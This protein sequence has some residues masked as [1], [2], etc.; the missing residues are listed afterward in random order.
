MNIECRYCFLWSV[1]PSMLFTVHSGNISSVLISDNILSHLH[2]M[3]KT[4]NKNS[5]KHRDY[6]TDFSTSHWSY[7][8][9]HNDRPNSNKN[10]S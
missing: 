7:I 8:H 2:K 3:F 6:F 5:Q 1:T 9:K 4:N 10:N